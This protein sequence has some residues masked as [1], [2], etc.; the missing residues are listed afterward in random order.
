M[1]AKSYPCALAARV[2]PLSRVRANH[3]YN[4]WV[5]PRRSRAGSSA[6][7]LFCKSDFCTF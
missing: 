7:Q 3:L 6:E 5:Y 1:V 2:L 4:S